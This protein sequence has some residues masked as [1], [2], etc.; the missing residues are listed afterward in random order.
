MPDVRNDS[1]RRRRSSFALP[2]Y[3]ALLVLALAVPFI[4]FNIQDPVIGIH[5]TNQPQLLGQDVSHG[6]IRLS[7][8]AIIRLAGTVPTGTPVDIIA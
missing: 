8:D 5:G 4:V 7:N 3:G 6:C 1:G 2:G